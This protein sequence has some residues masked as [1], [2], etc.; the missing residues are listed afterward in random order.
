M[1]HAA[2]DFWAE[3]MHGRNQVSTC[4]S[5]RKVKQRRSQAYVKLDDTTRFTPHMHG[6]PRFLRKGDARLAIKSL[7]Q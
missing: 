4:G 1:L 2:L 7:H 5:G 3:E 6:N